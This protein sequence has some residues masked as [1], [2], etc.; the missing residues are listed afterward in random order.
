MSYIISP[1]QNA[2]VPKRNTTDNTLIAHEILHTM[3]HKKRGKGGAMAIK[4]DL[5]QAYDKL[6]WASIKLALFS[7]QFPPRWV[8][9]I[10]ELM[11][12]NSHTWCS[13]Y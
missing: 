5:E 1:F 2:F 3:M 7:R 13:N 9:L 6:D 10:M 12:Y 11:H 8:D 4:L